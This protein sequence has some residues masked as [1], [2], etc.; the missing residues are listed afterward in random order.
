MTNYNTVNSY[1][2]GLQHRADALLSKFNLDS[3]DHTFILQY[4]IH[5][6]EKAIS[7]IQSNN[8]T[9]S[10]FRYGA[11]G[12]LLANGFDF[13]V[14]NELSNEQIFRLEASLRKGNEENIDT[15]W[16]DF[17]ISHIEDEH[18]VCLP[19]SES[20][21]DMICTFCKQEEFMDIFH[22]TIGQVKGI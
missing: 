4:P 9:I 8:N 5:D 7:V 3:H 18:E 13:D 17:G 22:Y 16:H 12:Y 19:L 21:G 11:S 6:A 2:K 15:V 20:V 14:F 10:I 1:N